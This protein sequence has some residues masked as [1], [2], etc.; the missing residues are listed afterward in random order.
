MPAGDGG[1]TSVGGGRGVGGGTSVGGGTGGGGSSSET[2]GCATSD[3]CVELRTTLAGCVTFRSRCGGTST[4][5]CSSGGAVHRCETSE[6]T[7]F[8]YTV[9]RIAPRQSS[10]SLAGGVFSVI[11]PPAAVGTPCS[12]QRSSQVC[13]GAWGALCSSLMCSTPVANTVCGAG[14]ISGQCVKTDGQVRVSYYSPTTAATAESSCLMQSDYRW[15][16]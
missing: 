7:Q 16:P 15:V 8:Y 4:A 1:G 14:S 10:C 3:S 9:G 2:C 6:S 13:V 11:P 12:C 5:S